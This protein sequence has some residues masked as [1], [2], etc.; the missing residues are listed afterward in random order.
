MIGR[1]VP[2][3]RRVLPGEHDLEGETEAG[4]SVLAAQRGK[5]VLK[6]GTLRGVTRRGRQNVTP[7]AVQ[8]A[9]DEA[10]RR[11]QEAGWLQEQSIH[12]LS[13]SRTASNGLFLPRRV[14]GPFVSGEST[15]ARSCESQP[16]A[17]QSI[18]TSPAAPR[19]VPLEI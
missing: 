16:Q 12:S 8:A 1:Y 15:P 14:W 2:W 3:T 5:T 11:S 10:M 7:E 6:R 13:F 17:A 9:I 18:V 19:K 4:W